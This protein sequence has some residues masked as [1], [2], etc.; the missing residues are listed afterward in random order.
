MPADLLIIDDNERIF[1]SLSMNF[2]R[3]G[4]TCRW[5]ANLAD[6]LAASREREP[7][8]AIIDLALGSESG[9]DVMQALMEI[10]P[11]LPVVFI[12]G[13]GTLEAAVSAMKL[14]AYDFLPKPLDF[15]R[16][17][18]VVKNAIAAGAAAEPGGKRATRRWSRPES[19]TAVDPGPEIVSAGGEMERLKEKAAKVALSDLPVLL[20]GESGTGKEL[21]A[22]YVHR[23]SPRRERPFVRINC[24]SITD[25]LA[26]SEFF[27]HA[28]G[29]F[30]GATAD[31][32]GL[33]Q[34]ADGG[35]LHLDEIGDMPPAAQA[36]IL[37]TLE[38]SLVR[39]VGG[40]GETPIDVRV[41]A[42]TNRNLGDLVATGQFREDLLY[43]IN[44]VH[45]HI[46]PLRE[47]RDDVPALIEHFL[48]EFAGGGAPKRFAPDAAAALAAYAWP[49][50]ARELKNIVKVCA[51]LSAGDSIRWDEL[52]AAVKSPPPAA[53]PAAGI[54]GRMNEVERRAIRDVLAEVGGNR[55]LAAER[56]GI[57]VRTLY[58]K[59]DRY[60]LS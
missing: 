21:L 23:H 57:S 6:A 49:G 38:T 13:F 53:P 26:D 30:T 16:L 11:E 27:G 52:P 1:T 18:A 2:R 4:F 46:P 15:K 8:A 36:K 51:L 54:S 59:L 14:G 44:A 40:I 43:R 33:F 45:L 12:S 7:S 55:R 24:S 50:N 20:T 10:L 22:E 31:H 39:P 5:A 37:R 3:N 32:R 47:R 9:L 17:L 29:S 35:T 58:Y 28:R 42:S 48:D 25:S 56:L 41:V 60:G 19:R 34:Q